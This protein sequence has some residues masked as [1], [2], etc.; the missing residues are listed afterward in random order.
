MMPNKYVLILLFCVAGVA[1]NAQSNAWIHKMEIKLDSLMLR[2]ETE[3]DVEL[4]SIHAFWNQLVK[5]SVP[6]THEIRAKTVYFIEE[7]QR[8]M[9]VYGIG[10]TSADALYALSD[11]C[12]IQEIK[13][14]YK[15]L[16]P[17][18]SVYT[19]RMDSIQ[20]SAVEIAGSYVDSMNTVAVE[21]INAGNYENREI[22]DFLGRWLEAFSAKSQAKIRADLKVDLSP[23]FYL[24]MLYYFANARDE[25]DYLVAA[26]FASGYQKNQE[27]TDRYVSQITELSAKIDERIR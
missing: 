13:T 3:E 22:D 21:K 24:V 20:K 10:Y 19:I 25:N 1:G 8:R 2:H 12:V 15:N 5:A 27:S 7:Y 6:V 4:D 17:L 14:T 11:Y 18:K 9:G 26:Y 23:C 16:Y